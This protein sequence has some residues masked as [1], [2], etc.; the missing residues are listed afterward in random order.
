MKGSVNCI[1]EV[2]KNGYHS[3]KDLFVARLCLE[4]L[5]RFRNEQKCGDKVKLIQ[6]V[7]CN[8]DPDI[9]N[10]PLM[11]F[12]TLIIESIQV[13]DF[14]FYKMMINHYKP[15]VDRDPKLVEYLD[16]VAKYYFD[17]Q[18]IKAANP[19][20][21]MIQNMMSTANKQPGE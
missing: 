3:E 13:Q 9:K 20:Q 21:Q 5:I 10:S 2:M 4:I 1:K 12:I 17:G 15:Q 8:G 6:G 18:T 7:F 16:R 11:N 19:M 14:E